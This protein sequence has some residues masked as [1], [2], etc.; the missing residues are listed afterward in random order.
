ME[1]LCLLANK[2]QSLRNK[3]RAV[4]FLGPLA[5][6]LYLMPVFWMAGS[7]K[8]GDIESTAAG[9]ATLTGDLACPSLN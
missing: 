5:L 3:T 6:R 7:K 8:P 2:D 9:L 1:K 4:D